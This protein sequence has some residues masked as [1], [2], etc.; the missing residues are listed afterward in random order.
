MVHVK[1]SVILTHVNGTVTPT[2]VYVSFG[3]D[4]ASKNYEYVTIYS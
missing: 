1:K 4:S 3:L 2:H